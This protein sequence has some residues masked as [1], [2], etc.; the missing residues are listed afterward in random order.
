M[1]MVTHT[2]PVVVRHPVTDQFEAMFRGKEVHD[3]AVIKAFPWLFTEQVEQATAAPG[4]RRQV[5]RR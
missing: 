1:A 2:S 3:Q 4:Q 5:N